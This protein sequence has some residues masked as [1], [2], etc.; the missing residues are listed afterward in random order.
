ME[1]K[2]GFKTTEAGRIP[3]TWDVK[4]LINCCDY[5]DY[6]GK[7]PPKT[8]R[9]TVLVTARNVREGFI[10][11]D[12]S[13]EYVADEKYDMIMRRGKPRIGD[14]LIT[15]EAPLG[16]IAQIDR[17]DV[18]LAQRIIKYRPKSGDLCPTYLKFYLLSDTFQAI[19]NSRGSGTT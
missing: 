6:R 7:M 2:D 13:K 11:Y 1:M 8:S 10:D 12:V 15:T 17:E 4:A 14:V 5:A 9:G 16:N 19:L 18:A 3:H